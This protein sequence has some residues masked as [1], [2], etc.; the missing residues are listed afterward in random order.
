MKYIHWH[1]W[2]WLWIL[3]TYVSVDASPD[4]VCALWYKRFNGRTY[5]IK[6]EYLGK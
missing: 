6:E 3:P 5:F 4:G 2:L 1:D